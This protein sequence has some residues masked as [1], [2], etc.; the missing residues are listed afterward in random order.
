MVVHLVEC[1]RLCRQLD[2]TFSSRGL[3]HC[4]EHVST[5]YYLYHRNQSRSDP[6][7]N[8]LWDSPVLFLEKFQHVLSRVSQR[9]MHAHKGGFRKGAYPRMQLGVVGVALLL[10]GFVE[11]RGR[12]SQKGHLVDDVLVL[13]QYVFVALAEEV[14]GGVPG[15]KEQ[16]LVVGFR[17]LDVLPDQRP[18]LA[19]GQRRIFLLQAGLDPVEAVGDGGHP[20][21]VRSREHLHAERLG[22]TGVGISGQQDLV[23]VLHGT[24]A[25][26]PQRRNGFGVGLLL[27]AVVELGLGDEEF[28]H[29]RTNGTGRKNGRVARRVDRQGRDVV[30]VP[31]GQQHRFRFQR[32]HVETGV[33]DDPQLGKKVGRR[34]GASSEPNDAQAPLQFHLSEGVVVSG[35]SNVPV[36]GLAGR[37]GHSRPLDGRQELETPGQRP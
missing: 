35:N 15:V 2:I 5:S 36:Q 27:V 3:V 8:I 13:G 25:K 17:D 24:H 32:F 21:L 33:Q 6:Q 37:F 9:P 14:D 7:D 26:G 1:W 12:L 10:G 18:E 11:F 29:Q 28:V 31:V 22:R 16:A 19:L 20:V 30:S 23:P 34:I 4:R